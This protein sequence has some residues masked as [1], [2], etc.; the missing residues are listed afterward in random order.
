M[1]QT[2]TELHALEQAFYSKP[3]NFS[4]SS[5]NKLLGSPKRFYKEYIL[6]DKEDLLDS[7]LVEGK[8]IHNLL[9]DNGTFDKYFILSPSKLP[10][11]STRSVI[12]KVYA[13]G[14]EIA[15]KDKI[16]DQ[17]LTDD[18]AVYGDEVLD[19]LKEINLHQSL[20]TDQQRLDK[21][22]TDES[23][24]Y[25]EFLKSKGGKT[26]VDAETL[27]K[28]TK[29][30]VD[31]KTNMKIRNLLGID[32]VN[33]DDKMVY[34]EIPLEASLGDNYPFGLKGILDNLVVDINTKTVWINDFKTTSKSLV[35]FPE[36]V[37]YYNYWLQAVIY[38]KLALE[39]LKGVLDDSWTIEIRF[40]VADK[41][42]TVYAFLVTEN[43]L[44]TW[45]ERYNTVL[46]HAKWHYKERNY[47]LP[48]DFALGNITL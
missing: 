44:K 27:D 10:G 16:V 39:F 18:L 17:F 43:T 26:L 2:G 37:E 32:H 14:K 8:L 35:D 23:K 21:I 38:K 29:A 6:K 22:I 11:D 13:I 1:I 46:E 28:C 41:S 31:I 19:I 36:T 47:N 48:Y 7:Y 15:E 20:K 45:E 9:L 3:F 30:A 4:Y 33:T 25:W 24:S 34:N 42:N 12:D 5:L 40:I